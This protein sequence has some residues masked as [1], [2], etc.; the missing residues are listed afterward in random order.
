MF[1]M[2]TVR[3]Y[4]EELLTATGSVTAV[5]TGEFISDGGVC[6]SVTTAAEGTC[7]AS[8]TVVRGIY[9]Q[10]WTVCT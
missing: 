4:S 10:G 8:Y 2:W 1:Q 5:R 9:I 6:S 3:T 7:F